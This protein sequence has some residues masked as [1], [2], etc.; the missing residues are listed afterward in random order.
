MTFISKAGE[1][2]WKYPLPARPRAEGHL[3]V[4]GRHRIYWHEY[5]NPTGEPVLF[6]HGGPGGGSSATD[7]RF[8]DP[9]R[10]RIVLFDQRGCGKSIPSAADDPDTALTHNT[11]RDLIADIAQLKS[12]LGIAGSM[13][14]FGGSWGSTLSLAYAIVQPTQV[15]TLILRGIFLCRRIDIDYFYQGNA[16]YYHTDAYDSRHPGT[17]L[18]FPEAW[19]PFVEAIPVNERRDMVKAYA[20]IFAAKPKS[21]RERKQQDA[22]AAAWS[23]WEGSTSYLAPDAAELAHFAEPGFARAFARIENHYFMNGAFFIGKGQKARDNNY[24]IEN[25][26]KIARLPIHIVQGQYDQVCPRFGADALVAALRK[27]KAKVNY[28]LTPAGHSARERETMLALSAIMD[29]LPKT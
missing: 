16:A 14:V 13:H 5:G 23:V 17:Y 26:R 2:D 10:Y 12:H 29:A 7:A 6:V 22:A 27:H 8:F 3:A 4:S 18:A 25:V 21:A 19:R 9:R 15:R 20:R 1:N 24:L 28:V 11:T